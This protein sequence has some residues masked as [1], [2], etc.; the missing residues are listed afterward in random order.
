[1]GEF[2]AR[3]VQGEGAREAGKTAL[4]PKRARAVS[5]AFSSRRALSSLASR[6]SWWWAVRPL[7]HQPAPGRTAGS[8]VRCPPPWPRSPPAQHRHH[9]TP[10]H[11][12]AVAE[13]AVC[14]PG[15]VR[16]RSR[17]TSPDPRGPRRTARQPAPCLPPPS[18]RR[19]RRPA[20]AGRVHGPPRTLPHRPPRIPARPRTTQNPAPIH[21]LAPDPVTSPTQ[22]RPPHHPAAV[23]L[24]TSTHPRGPRLPE[25]A[26]SPRPHPG[27]L[28]ASRPRPLAHRRLRRLPPH[29]RTLHPLGPHQQAHHRPR[30]RHP[31][32]RPHPATRRRAPLERRTPAPARRHPQARRPPCRAATPPL[33]P[34]TVSN[35]P[36]DHRRR[37]GRRSRSTP[38]TRQCTRPTARARRPAGPR[39]R[40][41]PQGARDHRRP[42]AVSMALPR[43]P[44]RTADQHHTADTTPQPA[45]N[46]S[47]PGSQH[48]T[49]PARHR[50]PRRDPR[51]HPGHPHRC[52]CRLAT[53]L[54][55]RLGQLRRRSQL[56]HT[57][58]GSSHEDSKK[59]T[60]T[61]GTF[62]LIATFYADKG[63][64]TVKAGH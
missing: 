39:C 4:D 56:S 58:D 17:P 59:R 50:D 2:G 51:P 5:A 10:H 32:E 46:S 61:H 19:R 60:T 35:P 38:P 15:P 62:N 64:A 54:R 63:Y 37:R 43:R 21:D 8:P 28:P 25:L 16:P 41:E 30:P 53:A 6:R 12:Q 45:R 27:H 29:G 48:R 14:L 11:H 55:R 44:A 34:R 52:R 49:L 18:P 22:Q 20:R 26:D 1:M 13:Q 40:R 42:G 31:L 23:Q 9:R 36:V 33:R 7:S 47:Q 24:R 3:G 57:R